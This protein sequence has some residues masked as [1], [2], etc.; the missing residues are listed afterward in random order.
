MA[1]LSLTD[2]KEFFT[3]GGLAELGPGPRKGVQS[4]SALDRKL[5]E[6]FRGAALPPANKQLV[7][8][9]I[10]LWHDHFDAAHEIAQDIATADGSFVHGILHRREPDYGNAQYWFRR[11]GEH[12]A[13]AELSANARALSEL[14]ADADLRGALIPN[15][16][17]NAMGM[18]RAC[19]EAAG[20]DNGEKARLLRQVQQ[21]E[22]E[23]LLGWLL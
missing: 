22:T 8:A 4:Q 16:K 18:I 15:G 7:R 9:L 17:W 13:F 10:L 14:K 21:A 11:V 1:A 20:Q 12:P 2:F 19:E 5:E 23:T 3:D 6:L